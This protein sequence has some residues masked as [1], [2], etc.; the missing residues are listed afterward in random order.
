MINL[1]VH[2]H[3]LLL[4]LLYCFRIHLLQTSFV[5]LED[6]VQ[7]LHLGQ[8]GRNASM[9]LSIFPVEASVFLMPLADLLIVVVSALFEASDQLLTQ[10]SPVR[11]LL[12]ALDHR[13]EFHLVPNLFGL[14]VLSH[15]L[16]DDVLVEIMRGDQIHLDLQV[17][18]HR[19]QLRVGGVI[20]ELHRL[21]LLVFCRQGVGVAWRGVPAVQRGFCLLYFEQVLDALVQQRLGL[22]D[23]LA[24]DF[25]QI[26][27]HFRLASRRFIDVV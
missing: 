6:R 27:N 11:L 4:V 14:F 7:A 19:Q 3:Q 24:L 18:V 12:N 5:L 2:L 25:D 10:S 21:Q 13:S 8:Q 16:F 26:L 22:D 1:L 23:E 20:L 9:T 15:E 17:P